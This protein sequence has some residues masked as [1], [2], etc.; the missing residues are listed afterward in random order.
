SHLLRSSSASFRIWDWEERSATAKSA[1]ASGNPFLIF[2]IASLAFSP[3][4]QTRMVVA[5]WPHKFL[6]VSKP[7]PVLAPVIRQILFFS[8]MNGS[9]DYQ[10]FAWFQTVIVSKHGHLFI[11][12]FIGEG[13]S[14]QAGNISPRPSTTN[15]MA[16]AAT[17]MPNILVK[18]TKNRS[19]ILASI[20]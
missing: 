13:P 15:C 4:R 9:L 5:P 6:A 1:F 12:S 18:A 3:E 14:S 7:I 10:L 17:I 19:F 11:L 8:I 20:L 16:M 2:F